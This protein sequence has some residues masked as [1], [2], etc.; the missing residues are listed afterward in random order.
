MK[1]V[2]VVW[3]FPSW[4][5]NISDVQL[6]IFIRKQAIALAKQGVK[7]AVFYMQTHHKKSIDVSQKQGVDEFIY[8]Y[9]K[10][11]ISIFSALHFIYHYIKAF[12]QFKKKYAKPNVIHAHV[13][14]PKA[15]MAYIVSL[16]YKCDFFCSEHWTGYE[17]GDF[18]KKDFIFKG[19]AT[20]VASKSKKLFVPS[21]TLL[22]SMKKSG[23]NANFHIMPNV[24]EKANST[25][26]KV[27]TKNT[28][29]FILVADMI[30][31]KKNI[32][33]AIDVFERVFLVDN[34]IS[35]LIIGG[36]VDE[37]KIKEKVEGSTFHNKNIQFI[38]RQENAVVLEK[39]EESSAGVIFSNVETFSVFA[40][41][42]L[43][44]GKPIICTR[45]GGPEF[46]VNEN[47]GIVIEKNDIEALY[48]AILFLKEQYN[49][50]NSFDISTEIQRK[51]S[52]EIIGKN[53]LEAYN[54]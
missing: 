47:N 46:F 15:F 23:F 10:S 12:L 9:P 11:S 49:N 18:A 28:F 37:D 35:L 42:V 5:P 4:Y 16:F 30:I 53:L 21:V 22:N 2:Q 50:Y 40:A 13:F 8:Y 51:F 36:G 25:I 3:F 52:S 48:S 54:S 34:T 29:Q 24:V 39:I 38:G 26:Y 32:V 20:F 17:S 45:C 14:Y 41:E 7:V 6:G 1:Q 19:L 43:I 27:K 31:E 44:A 33:A